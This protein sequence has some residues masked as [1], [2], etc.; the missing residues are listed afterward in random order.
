MTAVPFG[1]RE[2]QG[3]AAAREVLDEAIADAGRVGAPEAFRRRAQLHALVA[4]HALHTS[5]SR[6]RRELA[7]VGVDLLREPTR[8]KETLS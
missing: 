1:S 5:L 4:F 3:A 2:I 6:L 7:L 8:R